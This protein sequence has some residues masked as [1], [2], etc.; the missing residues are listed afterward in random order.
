M[1]RAL[2]RIQAARAARSEAAPPT[3]PGTMTRCGGWVRITCPYCGQ[4]H[5]HG[6]PN[7]FAGWDEVRV[8]LCAKPRP[9]SRVGYIIAPEVDH[10]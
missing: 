7:L 4:R 1:V 9:E 3:V 10:A 8:A 5:T 6:A 2:A